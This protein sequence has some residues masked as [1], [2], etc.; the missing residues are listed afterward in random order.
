MKPFGKLPDGREARLFSLVNARGARADIS[1]Y[2][3]TLVSLHMPDRA[4]EYDDIVLGFNRVEDY[5]R[6]PSYHGA[7]IGRVC[8]R[9]AHCRFTLDGRTHSLATNNTPGGIPCH[10]HGGNVGFDKV[11]WSAEPTT[12]GGAPA[13]RLRYLS[14]DG[15]EGYPG[16]LDVTVLYTLGHDNTLRCDYSATTDRTTPV[17]LTQHSYFNLRGEGRGDIL[18]HRLQLHA[19]RFTA[20]NAGAIPTGELAPVAGTPLDF[21]SAR[22]VGDRIDA[23][24]EQLRFAGGY[25]HNWVL[26]AAPGALALAASVEEPATGRTLEVWTEEPGI[27]F[28]AGNFLDGTCIGKRGQPYGYRQGFCLETQHFPDSVNQPTFPSTLLS[29]GE[30]YRTT[31][32]FKFGAH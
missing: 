22:V 26:D 4:G 3:A 5:V 18:G 12:N 9:T 32:L 25:D 28:Y 2:G 14:R 13:L 27:Q 19:T 29:P 31:T 15:E 1:D 21:T 11:L 24:H 7:I 20:I 8:N 6:S 10:L 16:N 17:A 30:T 23:P